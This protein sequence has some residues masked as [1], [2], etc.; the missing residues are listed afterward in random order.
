MLQASEKQDLKLFRSILLPSNIYAV[1]IRLLRVEEI[2]E[3][4]ISKLASTSSEFS[5]GLH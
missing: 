1:S 3:T 5:N 2:K 4:L